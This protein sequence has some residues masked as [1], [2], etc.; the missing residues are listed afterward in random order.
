MTEMPEATLLP[1]IQKQ[2]KKGQY[3][4]IIEIIEPTYLIMEKAVV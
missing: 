1:P 2:H 4:N 3:S